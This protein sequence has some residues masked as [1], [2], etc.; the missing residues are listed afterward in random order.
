MRFTVILTPQSF[1]ISILKNI[2]LV[3]LR[4]RLTTREI[5]YSHSVL[6]VAA[7]LQ[8]MIIRT[9]SNNLIY[10][11][12]KLV[13]IASNKDLWVSLAITNSRT[14]AC[15]SIASVRS[16]W[17]CNAVTAFRR[18]AVIVDRKYVLRHLSYENDRSAVHEDD[19]STINSLTVSLGQVEHK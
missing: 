9:L 19:G 3:F 14:A 15:K 4:L 7:D 1:C 8:Y 16:L 12:N 18:C 10:F 11:D 5:C 2:G 6:F 17:M 13:Y